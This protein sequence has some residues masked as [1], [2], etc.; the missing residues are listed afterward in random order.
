MI[1]PHHEEIETVVGQPI[2]IDLA[3]F[4]VVLKLLQNCDFIVQVM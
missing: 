3:K 4:L 1:L 2:V